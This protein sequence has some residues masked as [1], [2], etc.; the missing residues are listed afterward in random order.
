M[1]ERGALETVTSG[2]E[3]SFLR[4][5]VQSRLLPS[6]NGADAR[7]KLSLAHPSVEIVGIRVLEI[8][9]TF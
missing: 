6:L 1:G 5:R 4:F 9:L 7:S 3:V 8:G 2:V